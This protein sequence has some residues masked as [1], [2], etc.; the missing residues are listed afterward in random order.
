MLTGLGDRLT[1]RREAGGLG[2]ENQRRN[3]PFSHRRCAPGVGRDWG[4]G[5]VEA[6][7]G[8]CL[9][10]PLQPRE[11]PYPHASFAAHQRHGFWVGSTR[12]WVWLRG[13][14]EGHLRASEERVGGEGWQFS[15]GGNVVGRSKQM[16]GV[17]L[18]V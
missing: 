10:Y 13:G 14:G 18:W 5:G 1:G 2:M 4:E 7:A 16:G 17:L 12:K 6:V 3:S 9:L 8:V 15:A 11:I